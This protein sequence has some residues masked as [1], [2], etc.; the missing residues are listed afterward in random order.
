MT[1]TKPQFQEAQRT[2]SRVNTKTNTTSEHI[3]IKLPRTR[4]EEKILK[5]VRE[6][7]TCIQ[8]SK[9]NPSTL[10]V[11]KLAS[12]KTMKL[13]LQCAEMKIKRSYINMNLPQAY[14][15]SPC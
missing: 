5:E 12:K 9:H 3:I 2:P 4:D 6:T 1:G 8:R 10:L 15:C 7:N 11:R 13:H 14:T